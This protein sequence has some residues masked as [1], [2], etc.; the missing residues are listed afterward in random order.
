MDRKL[1]VLIIEDSEDDA[2]L[3]LHDLK[4][5]GFDVVSKRVETA[6]E[7]M[8]AITDEAWDIALTDYSLPHFTALDAI[9]LWRNSVGSTPIIVV[10]GAIGEEVA[11]DA[12]QA[13][14]NDYVMKDRR[15]RLVP[16]VKRALEE[17]KTSKEKREAELGLSDSQALFSAIVAS[18]HDGIFTLD[19]DGLVSFWNSS[20]ARMFGVAAREMT[21]R[22]IKELITTEN[23]AG[24]LE[25]ALDGFIG[26]GGSATAAHVWECQ[27]HRKDDEVFPIELSIATMALGGKWHAVG[28][29]RDISERV[30]AT[31]AL[32]A[33]QAQLI[34]SE[35]M[36][37]IGTLAAGVAHEINN[38]L[39]YSISNMQ[40]LKGY[41]EIHQRIID[42]YE[43]ALDGTFEGAPDLDAVNSYKKQVCYAQSKTDAVDAIDDCADGLNKISVIVNGLRGFSRKNTKDWHKCA[44]TE[45]LENALTIVANELKYK[46]EII[47]EYQPCP[48]IECL[49][50]QLSQVF[51][52]LLI[53]ASQALEDN[54]TITLRTG[55]DNEMVWVEVEDTG[56]GIADEAIDN[57]FEPFFTTKSIDKGTGLGLFVSSTIMDK[58][59]GRIEV[60]SEAGEGTTFRVWL[61]LAQPSA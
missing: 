5:G 44:V 17:T 13:G 54:G 1:R 50:D 16:A 57:I 2:L 47:K 45:P 26:I 21:G 52:N 27:G 10:S 12:L 33:S 40:T 7:M 61:P 8:S 34:Q 29:M 38:P 23:N 39:S 56:Q 43:Q 53:N 37:A 30:E 59:H 48:D 32:E 46:C 11:V 49:P 60:H 14:A 19:V 6:Q 15:Q 4:Q 55:S 58:H 51:M 3:S 20:A 41:F 25:R 24:E 36:A 9:S 28:I 42:G 18:V 35:K 31:R 22:S